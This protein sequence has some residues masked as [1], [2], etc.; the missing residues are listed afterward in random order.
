MCF[1]SVS[2]LVGCGGGNGEEPKTAQ[3]KASL[4]LAPIDELKSIPKDLEAEMTAITR[5]ID[6]VQA[7]VDDLGK[8]PAKLKLNKSQLVAL[9][10]ASFD[11]GKVE[12]K[13]DMDLAAEA[14]AEV[15][16]YLKRIAAVVA[17]LKATPDKVAGLTKKV[18]S[19]TARVPVLA[20]KVT[21][22]ATATVSNPFGDASAKAK[23]QAD[24][25]G[26]KKA[27]ED[28]MKSVNDI[29]GKVAGIPEMATNALAKLTASFST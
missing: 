10:K 22:S 11:N 15:E 9:A 25:D 8:L 1:A 28:V 7:I 12:V 16:A 29:Q 17:D 27:Q 2:W 6:E 20:T 19:A 21:A 14:K 23:A 13:L 3:A 4:E 5:P 18:A 26:V 24:L